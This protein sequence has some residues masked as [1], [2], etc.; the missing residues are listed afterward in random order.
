VGFHAAIKKAKNTDSHQKPE[1]RGRESSKKRQ[2]W[3]DQA[4]PAHH[5]RRESSGNLP[6]ENGTDME[7]TKEQRRLLGGDRVVKKVVRDDEARK[8]PR[9]MGTGRAS[10]F[11]RKKKKTEDIGEDKRSAILIIGD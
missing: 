10:I 4:Q 9:R 5:G 3:A 7:G 6:D 11:S 8:Y 2:L 1:K